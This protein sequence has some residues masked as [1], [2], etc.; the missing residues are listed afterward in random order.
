MAPSTRATRGSASAA[1]KRPLEETDPNAEQAQPAAKKPTTKKATA[2]KPVTEKPATKKA[3]A[4]KAPA[5][6]ATAKKAAA[7]DPPT[8]DTT[9]SDSEPG[10]ATEAA[11]EVAE[12][13]PVASSSAAATRRIA[14]GPHGETFM[15]NVM[16]AETHK[17]ISKIP[18]PGSW[19]IAIDATPERGMTLG[20]RE[21]WEDHESWLEKNKTKLKLSPKHWAMKDEALKKDVAMKDDEG[22]QDWD[23]ICLSQASNEDE[24]D[25]DE[26]YNID[27][28]DEDEGAGQAAGKATDDFPKEP[29]PNVAGKLASLH[30]DWVRT[31]SMLG[32][33]RARWW[34]LEATKRD[35][36]D[37]DMHIYNDF[38]GYGRIEV[39]ENIFLQFDSVLKKRNVSYREIWPEVEGFAL[40][41][42]SHLDSFIMCDDGAK[43]GVV[44]EM[45]GHLLVAAVDALKK[46]GVFKPDSDI[47]NL[48]FILATWLEWGYG[49]DDYGF[50]DGQT[51]WVYRIFE[52]A[53]EAGVILRGWPAE[54]YAKV[55]ATIK[56]DNDGKSASKWKPT[57]WSTRLKSYKTRYA[58]GRAP[59]R[60]GGDNYDITKKSAQERKKYSFA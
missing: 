49:L 9:A 20:S 8:E 44:V 30:P 55:F 18:M 25:E 29:K 31:I 42:H 24:D 40:V 13:A 47:P 41:M 36:D 43:C 45:V 16:P 37:F 59:A 38:S 52:L 46:Q 1:A 58:T 5:K 15:P 35:Q 33:D 6:K 60:I 12:S 26:F 28:D 39:I 10:P 11:A 34:Q 48:G 2:K 54:K 3:P 57:T 7:A 51:D 19:I 56:E 50:D 32:Q 22:N 21:W 17:E 14:K 4:K 23:F 53:E 27:D